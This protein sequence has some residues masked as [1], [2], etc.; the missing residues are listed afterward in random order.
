MLLVLVA[1]R[2]QLLL[3]VTKLSLGSHSSL[4]WN[5]KRMSLLLT[6][7]VSTGPTK[8]SHPCRQPYTQKKAS[9]VCYPNPRFHPGAFPSAVDSL[10]CAEPFSG[11]QALGALKD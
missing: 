1:S 5:L 3:L 10:R 6:P 11:E 4:L 2:G 8:A 9:S 7:E